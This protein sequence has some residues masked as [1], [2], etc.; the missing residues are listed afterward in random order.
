MRFEDLESWKDLDIEGWE[1]WDQSYEA[2]LP[3]TMAFWHDNILLTTYYWQ[4]LNCAV[5]VSKSFDGEYIARA[6]Q[7]FGYG[8][9]RG[10]SS[11]GGLSSLRKMIKL[12]NQGVR[13]TFTV[14]G[15]RGPK[16]KV[17]KGVIV[18][19]RKIGLPIVPI[20]AVAKKSWTLNNW[21]GTQIPKPFSRAKVFTSTPVFVPA[22][23]DEEM[24]ESKRLELERK[25]D[26]LV[27][28]GEEWRKAKS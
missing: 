26:E 24:I 2:D 4:H 18:L 19:S 10:S 14:D 11:R 5:L 9:I 25:L 23:A 7:R 15:P 27:S 12:S 8:I 21:D 3:A 20:M 6:A 22:D 28:L 16:H 17:K 1:S 13:M